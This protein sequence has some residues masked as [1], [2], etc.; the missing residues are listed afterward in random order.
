[1]PRPVD[2]NVLAELEE[3]EIAF[4]MY[5]YKWYDSLIRNLMQILSTKYTKYYRQVLSIL[6]QYWCSYATES[7][8]YAISWDTM[9]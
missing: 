4:W 2:T 3:I 7:Q 5:K 8:G 6:K 1:M 9:Y